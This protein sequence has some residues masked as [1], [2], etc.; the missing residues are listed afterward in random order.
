MAISTT[1][2]QKT[3]AVQSGRG[4]QK[5]FKENEKA[6]EIISSG[7][8]DAGGECEFSSGLRDAPRGAFLE[9]DQDAAAQG[10]NVQ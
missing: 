2:L 4:I 6:K 9:G 7:D 10:A 1:R 3:S 5:F 8:R